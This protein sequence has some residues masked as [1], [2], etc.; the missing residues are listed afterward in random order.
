VTLSSRLA[1]GETIAALVDRCTG[2][3]RIGVDHLVLVTT[4]PWQHG[5]DLDVVLE[6]VDPIREVA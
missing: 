4:G 2:L 3:T 1:P 5:G 6:A